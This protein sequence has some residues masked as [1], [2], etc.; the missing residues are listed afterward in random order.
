ML[1]AASPRRPR[2]AYLA[3]DPVTA[4]RLLDG[5]LAYLRRQGF[6]VTVIAGPGELLDRVAEREQVAVH[7]VRMSRE[8]DPWRDT[9]ALVELVRLLAR[10]KPDLVNAGTPKAGLLG[11]LAARL[12]RVPIIVYLLRGLRFEGANGVTRLA[13]VA[14]EHVCG[15]LSHRVFCNSASLRARFVALGC[16]PAARTFVPAFGSSNGVDVERFSASI[17]ARAWAERE[18]RRRNIAKDAFV[19][20]FVGRFTRDKGISE[21]IQSFERVTARLPTAHLLLVGDHDATDPLSATA[22]NWL[23][24]AA[25]VTVTGFEREPGRYYA[26]MDVLAFPSYREGFPNVPLEAGAAALPCV[27]FRATGTVD[28]LI[29]GTTGVVVAAGDI[30][31]FANALLRYAADGDLARAHGEAARARVAAQFR[32]ELVWEAIAAEYR[33][34][35][36][37]AGLPADP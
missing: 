21:L 13:S 29:D 5:Q 32:R 34:L 1:S 20:G 3:T 33:R 15:T 37:G 19:V 10:L 23:R 4:F 16:A 26:M 2:V 14:A 18:R 7:A 11:V 28:A 24:N 30:E 35:L 27:A 12:A 22:Q 9:L 6:D 31:S 17:E 36:A 25:N 8:I